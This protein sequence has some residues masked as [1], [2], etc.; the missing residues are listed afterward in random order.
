MD[1][2]RESN[3]EHRALVDALRAGDTAAA[4]D[5]ARGTWKCSTGPCSWGCWRRPRTAGPGRAGPA[6]LTVSGAPDGRFSAGAVCAGPGAPRRRGR[7]GGPGA[8]AGR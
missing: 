3:R 8:G 6:E 2:L 5:I 1:A 7:A 4:A